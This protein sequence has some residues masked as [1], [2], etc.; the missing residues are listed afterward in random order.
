MLHVLTH[1]LLLQLPSV[2]SQCRQEVEQLR[3]EAS[4]K[5]IPASQAIDDIKVGGEGDAVG[6]DLLGLGQGFVIRLFRYCQLDFVR[7]G[8]IS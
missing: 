4:I 7:A 5:R 2:I 6:G 8:V 1:P 3:R